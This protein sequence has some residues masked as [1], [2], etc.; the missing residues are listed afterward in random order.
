MRD[1]W[2]RGLERNPLGLAFLFGGL[3]KLKNQRK[4]ATI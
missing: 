3:N 4:L 2:K 1:A